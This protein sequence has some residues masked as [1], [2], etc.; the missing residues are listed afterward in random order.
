MGS[1]DVVGGG[2]GTVV[3]LSRGV[4]LGCGGAII[5]WRVFRVGFL[6]SIAATDLGRYDQLHTIGGAVVRVY[7]GNPGK[8]RTC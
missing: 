4:Y 3:G 6:R 5:R 8:I 1:G 2:G 7:G